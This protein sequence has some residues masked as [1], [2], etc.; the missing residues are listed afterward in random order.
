MFVP[1]PPG[2]EELEVLAQ[3]GGYQPLGWHDLEA[4]LLNYD[5]DSEK[6]DNK[7]DDESEESEAGEGEDNYRQVPIVDGDAD[8]ENDR[9]DGNDRNERNVGNDG[10]DENDD[11]IKE[12]MALFE[13]Y[14]STSV[15]QKIPDFV[16]QSLSKS[17]YLQT[18]KGMIHPLPDQKKWPEV[19]ACVMI[20][21]QTE[22]LISPPRTVQPSKPRT[23]RKREPNEPSKGGRSG[24]VVC[25]LCLEAGHNKRICKKKKTTQTTQLS[26]SQ[27][28]T[29]QPSITESQPHSQVIN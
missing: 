3:D 2:D 10:N 11:I 29:T 21:G 22:H 7:N 16:H 19:S 8:D 25:T 27:P 28:S 9:N 26:S 15:T 17:A 1:N 4:E 24:T 13:G 23:Q 6:D 20:Q 5:G 14:Q 18:Y 12:C